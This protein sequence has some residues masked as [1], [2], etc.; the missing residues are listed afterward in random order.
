MRQGQFFYKSIYS[1][2]FIIYVNIECIVEEVGKVIE[3]LFIVIQNSFYINQHIVKFLNI[4]HNISQFSILTRPTYTQKLLPMDTKTYSY[5]YCHYVKT[6]KLRVKK[7]IY[8]KF[9]L[10]LLYSKPCCK[11]IIHNY[12]KINIGNLGAL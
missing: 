7:Y 8:E 11:Y 6:R 4:V 2:Y 12:V 1:L 5:Y 10:S 3:Q 9:I